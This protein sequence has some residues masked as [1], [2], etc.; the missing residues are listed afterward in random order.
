MEYRM[1]NIA[2]QPKDHM[3]NPELSLDEKTNLA[4]QELQMLLVHFERKAR[5][6]KKV[7]QFYKYTSILLAGATSIFSSLQLIY[8]TGIPPWILPVVSA[9]ATVTV[10]LLGASTSHKIWIN[11]RTTGQQLQVEG[12]LFN[13]QADGYFNLTVE[14]RLKLFSERMIK[15]WNEGH[16][17]WEKTVNDG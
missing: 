11:S 17:K 10:S 3:L 7:F 4:N 12:F 6:A 1:L 8:V 16:G 2:E 5:Q 14:E 13:Q 15:I 9:G